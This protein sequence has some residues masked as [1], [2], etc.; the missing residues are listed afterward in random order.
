MSRL[1][2]VLASLAAFLAAPALAQATPTPGGTA[3]VILG[4]DPENLNAAISTGYPI[5]AVGAS[6]YSALVVPAP[7]APSTA[8]S[9]SPGPSPTTTSSTPSPC[10]T[11]PSTTARP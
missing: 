1:F 11:P 2:I 9:P 3:I 5:G 7:T 10:A 6:V 8:S 4:S